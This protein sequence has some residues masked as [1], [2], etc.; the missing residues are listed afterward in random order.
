MNAKCN[1][2]SNR[3]RDRWVF[4]GPSHRVQLRVFDFTTE[5]TPLAMRQP[6]PQFA[7]RVLPNE[8]HRMTKYSLGELAYYGTD[9]DDAWDAMR[10]FVPD[11]LE[12]CPPELRDYFTRWSTT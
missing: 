2:K 8:S 5:G 12:Q 4:F 10:R 3:M 7:V 11:M 6:R 9:P 1:T